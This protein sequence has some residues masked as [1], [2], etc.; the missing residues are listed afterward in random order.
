MKTPILFLVF[1]RPQTTAVVFETIRKAKPSRLYVA[2]DGPRLNRAGESELVEN[3]RKIMTSVD[4]PC[5]IHTLFREKNMGCKYAVSSAITWFFEHE[6]QGIILEDDCVPNDDFF[7]YCETLLELYRDDH[8]IMA[9]TGNNF[10]DGHRRGQS[11]YYFSK[12]THIWGWASWRRAWSHYDV[13]I[14]FWPTWKNSHDWKS[15]WESSVDREHWQKIFDKVYD[16]EI[17]TW[18]CQWALC[19]WRQSGLTAIPNVNLVS[20][21]GFGP[22][23]THTFSENSRDSAIPTTSIG[24]IIHP[25]NVKSN[26]FAD[27]YT[28]NFHYGLRLKRFPL[29][30]F[31]F[32]IRVTFRLLQLLRSQ[33]IRLLL[34]IFKKRDAN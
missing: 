22:D 14:S 30:I 3:V 2:S 25:I 18:D 24:E 1:N 7:I 16:S 23:A 26:R 8:R 29:V 33:L 34:Y 4:W 11:S 28:A 5:E 21:I 17:D 9:I 13:E 32:P 12:L 31:Y 10:Q 27:R 20:N 6:E 19:L 15:F